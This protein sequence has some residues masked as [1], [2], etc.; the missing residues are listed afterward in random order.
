MVRRPIGSC[1]ASRHR[2][3]AST[4]AGA[5]PAWAMLV[6]PS[7]MRCTAPLRLGEI[8]REGGATRAVHRVQSVG[9]GCFQAAFRAMPLGSASTPQCASTAT[10]RADTRIARTATAHRYFRWMH[11]QCDSG[12]GEACA[13]AAHSAHRLGCCFPATRSCQQRLGSSAGTAMGWAGTVMVWD[14]SCPTANR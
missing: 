13:P 2:A 9:L 11:C 1:Q 8:W 5:M 3:G 14:E 7:L 4:A 10:G 12:L 6:L